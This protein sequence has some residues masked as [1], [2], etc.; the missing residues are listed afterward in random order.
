LKLKNKKCGGK[1]IMAATIRVLW[2]VE[3]G[4]V[5]KDFMD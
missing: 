3:N 1:A 2:D 4:S 5:F